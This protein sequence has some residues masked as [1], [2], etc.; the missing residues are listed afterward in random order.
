M[1][2][3]D[4]PFAPTAASA[5]PIAVLKSGKVVVCLSGRYAG[6][7]A[8]VVKTID[9]GSNSRKF[10]HALVAGIDRYPRRVTRSMSNK[11]IKKRCKVKPFVKFVNLNHIMPTRY[12]LKRW[13]GS[14]WE[15]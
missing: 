4:A 14:R 3:T 9:N 8:I 10:G 11:K 6:K 12:V 2:R 1:G 13:E 5:P 7:K 15:R